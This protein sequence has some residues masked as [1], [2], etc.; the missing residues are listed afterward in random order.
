METGKRPDTLTFH[1]DSH[2]L[3][4]RL[5]YEK[6]PYIS[7]LR[8]ST[9]QQE[10][11]GLGVEAQR[12]II[13]N[14]LREEEPLAEF[15]ETESGRHNNRPILKEAL[16]LCRKTGATLIVAKL[17][18]LSR[19]VAF[20]S[21]LLE[22]DVEIKFCDFPEANKLVLHIISSIAEYEAQLISTRTRQS[23][24]AKKARGAKLGKPENLTSNLDEAVA[25]SRATNQ[26]KARENANNKRAA[27]MLRAVIKQNLTLTQ[28]ADM[29]NAEGFV[30][31]RGSRFSPWAVSVLIKRYNLK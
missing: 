28:M 12:E 8:Q 25:H 26:R 2:I 19:N 27:A 30:T 14:Y 6:M 9:K 16:A 31:S 17:D 11:S 22:S 5:I 29:L 3:N 21:Q 4:G 24:E 15:V 23:L 13:R 7:Y 1:G 18:R 10:A 20:T